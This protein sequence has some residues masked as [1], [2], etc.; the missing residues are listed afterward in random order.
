MKGKIFA[1]LLG[2]IGAIFSVKHVYASTL[3]TNYI[4]N[5]YAYHYK[6]GVLRSYGKLPYRY[7]DGI[8]AYCIEPDRVINTYSYDS[9]TDFSVSGYSED[10]KKQMELIAHYGYEYPGHNTKEYY[11]ATQ[12]LIWL[13]SDDYVKWVDTY[14]EDGSLGN[15]LSVENE[16]NEILRL[17][18][19]HNVVPSTL[20]PTTTLYYDEYASINVDHL[21]DNYDI[22]SP[23]P[24][25]KNGSILKF[26]ANKFGDHR[27]I[28]RTKYLNGRTT[29]LYHV[30]GYDTQMMATFGLTDVKTSVHIIRTNIFRPKIIKKDKDTN[31]VL[32]GAKFQVKYQNGNI[33]YPNM[34]YTTSTD[35][36]YVLIPQG[37][38][39]IEEIKA[40][41]GYILNNEKIEI[42]VKDGMDLSKYKEIIV[43]NEKPKGNISI[44]KTDEEGNTLDNV[45]IGLYNS[46]HELIDT[47]LTSTNSS[48]N[49]LQLGTYFIKELET[50]NGY[51][52]DDKEYKIDLTY[53][54]EN[55]DIINESIDI[56]NEKIRCDIAY[57]SKKNIEGIKFNVYDENNNIVFS[58]VTN[59]DGLAT[60]KDLPYGK[61]YIKQI[62]VPSGYILNEEEFIFYVN[63]STCNTSIRIDND[64]TV[65][66]ITSKSIN[67]SMIITLILSTLGVK[68][69]VKKNN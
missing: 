55:T 69:Y 28:F 5:V 22:I 63:D 35:G 50:I 16:K 18:S 61:Y 66:P 46:N 30:S 12:E 2:I 54:D 34:N 57:I 67:I 14:S 53:K 1:V 62:E 26:H 48:F 24:Y 27:I 17:V 31:E 7:Q 36:V 65:M 49:D 33:V 39:T 45:K 51:K 11:M 60:I 19:N 41:N 37:K 21:T 4:D 25:E 64:E 59:E 43:Y 6:D 9:T 42:E 68:L 29:T 32:S 47:L 58:S 40:P 20:N 15:Q 10:V 52:L 44:N 13:F 23:I 3:T 38:Y 8:I 56:I